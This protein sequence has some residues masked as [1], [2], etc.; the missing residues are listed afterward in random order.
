MRMAEQEGEGF[1]A[2]NK[3]KKSERK[4]KRQRGNG[5]GLHYIIIKEKE[6]QSCT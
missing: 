1:I 2:E 6:H 3:V 5:G 4:K